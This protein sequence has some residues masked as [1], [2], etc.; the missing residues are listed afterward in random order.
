[1]PNNKVGM[2]GKAQDD[3]RYRRALHAMVRGDEKA[4]ATVA[5][6]QLTGRGGAKVDADEAVSLLY[7]CTKDRNTEAMWML[8]LCCEYGEGTEQDIDQAVSLYQRA[9]GGYGFVAGEF[10]YW[11]TKGGR[12]TGLMKVDSLLNDLDVLL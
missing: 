12:G 2:S 7:E 1:M 5:F 11:N 4:K 10:L 3:D 8:G 9:C 6:Y